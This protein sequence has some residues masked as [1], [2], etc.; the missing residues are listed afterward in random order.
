MHFLL[1]TSARPRSSAS[2]C[3]QDRDWLQHR[4]VSRLYQ[5]G[6][7]LR[8]E[9][10]SS[11]AAS[12]SR[13]Y[14]DDRPSCCGQY[15]LKVNR[16]RLS[17]RAGAPLCFFWRMPREAST[18]CRRHAAPVLQPAV[19]SPRHSHPQ[20]HREQHPPAPPTDIRRTTPH[21]ML[22]YATPK[23]KKSTSTAAPVRPRRTAPTPKMSIPPLSLLPSMAASEDSSTRR[24]SGKGSKAGNN[25][26]HKA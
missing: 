9:S 14:S 26:K 5:L 11:T 6:S 10:V 20:H 22:K 2:S 3:G 19:V 12:D 21:K 24:Q 23:T 18:A 16:N 15:S 4:F 1:A 25:G 17:F 13:M 8:P 7:T